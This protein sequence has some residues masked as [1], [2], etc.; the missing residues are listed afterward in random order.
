MTGEM[1]KVK[2]KFASLDHYITISVEDA[3]D[4]TKSLQTDMQK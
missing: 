4:R 3:N 1:I 2:E